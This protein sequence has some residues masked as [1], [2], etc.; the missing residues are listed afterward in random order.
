VREALRLLASQHLIVTTRGV[1]GGSFVV[2]PSPEQLT[3]TVVTGVNL[4]ITSRLVSPRELLEA[5]LFVE[6]PAAALVAQR[7]SERDLEALRQT[8]FD[9]RTA[10]LE[11]MAV[12]HSAF[13]EAMADACGNPLLTLI[14]KPLH[15]IANAQDVLSRFGRTFWMEV[16]VD[17]RAILAAVAD[18]EPEQ[19]EE[20]TARH[21]EHLRAAFSEPPNGSTTGEMVVSGAGGA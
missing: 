4:L 2:H 13:H 20:A 1:A 11:A 15:R 16:D 3:D 5:R 6:V 21:I 9:P 18:Q 7:R 10:E 17:H 12:V 19:A 8:L 14:A